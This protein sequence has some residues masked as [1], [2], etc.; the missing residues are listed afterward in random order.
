MQRIKGGSRHADGLLHLSQKVCSGHHRCAHMRRI[1]D[2]Q[3]QQDKTREQQRKVGGIKKRQQDG[4]MVG[5]MDRASRTLREKG[6]RKGAST[7]L[8]S[9]TL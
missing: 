1:R 6:E 3:P 8:R 9:Q 5:W 4:W 7:D 2:N